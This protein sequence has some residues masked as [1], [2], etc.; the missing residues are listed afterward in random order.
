MPEKNQAPKR[1]RRTLLDEFF[2]LP[3]ILTL[4]RIVVIP[5][6]C[7]MILQDDHVAAFFATSLYGAA[8]FTD[9]IDGYLARKRKQITI[10]GKFLDPL[11]DKLIV[12]SIMIT[13]LA[14]KRIPLWVVGLM[15]AREI[16]IT[17]LRAIATTEGLVIQA[18]PL[19]KFKTAFQMIGLVGLL[20]HYPFIINMGVYIGEFNFHNMGMYFIYLS[21]V[22]S[23]TSALDYFGGFFRELK[24][25]RELGSGDSDSAPD[26]SGDEEAEEVGA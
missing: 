10:I 18:R 2:N 4:G 14:M 21:L 22:F 13:M 17:G 12:L 7:F 23:I 15:L 25:S 20:L 6:I 11:A 5:F 16:T 26:E 24:R 9:M 1:L 19:G 3:N 8:A